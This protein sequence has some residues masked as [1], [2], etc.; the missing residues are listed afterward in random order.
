MP[1][2]A[3]TAVP[4]HLNL[5]PGETGTMTFTVVLPPTFPAGPHAIGVEVQ[6]GTA[7]VERWTGVLNLEVAAVPAA[8]LRVDPA[9]VTGGRQVET[10]AILSNL[11]NDQREFVLTGADPEH[12]TLVDVAPARV[13]LGP[14]AESRSRVFVR[15]GRHLVGS[16]ILRL[17][18]V[19]AYDARRRRAATASRCALGAAPS[20]ARSSPGRCVP[21]PT[22]CTPPPAGPG[23]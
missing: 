8:A 20:R 18:T 23:R 15:A 2:E 5:F 17:V 4:E 1:P 13:Q 6:T 7:P 19:T 3:V 14:G 16:P 10:A 22:P 11:G 9:A 21:P 12:A